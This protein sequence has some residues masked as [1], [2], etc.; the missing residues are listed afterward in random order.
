MALQ[1]I[2]M[3][4]N[5]VIALMIMALLFSGCATTNIKHLRTEEFIAKARNFIGSANSS[6]CIGVGFNRAYIEYADGIT[7]SGGQHTVVYWTELQ[8][9]PES[10]LKMF[11]KDTEETWS[12]TERDNKYF[13]QNRA[14]SATVVKMN[15]AIYVH[16]RAYEMFFTLKDSREVRNEKEMKHYEQDFDS[17]EAQ[18]RK[19]MQDIYNKYGVNEKQYMTY[20]TLI[21]S[22]ANQNEEHHKR[23]ED[24]ETRINKEVLELI[25]TTGCKHRSD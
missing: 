8:Q 4:H 2:E 18:F 6:N 14:S 24:L 1:E 25:R 10:F 17:R 7:I 11:K 3:K 13:Y 21:R 16:I 22:L 5:I 12:W 20:F 15:D 19:S 9:L 23:Y